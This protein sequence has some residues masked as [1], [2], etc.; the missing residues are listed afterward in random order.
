VKPVLDFL[1]HRGAP[2]GWCE[3]QISV[4]PSH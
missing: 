4:A 3:R 2:S 1:F